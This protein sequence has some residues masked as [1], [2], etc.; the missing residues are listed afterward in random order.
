M[1]NPLPP[2]PLSLRTKVH[3]LLDA[4]NGGSTSLE[5]SMDTGLLVLVLVNALAVVLESVLHLR[6]SYRAWF[7]GIELVSVCAFTLE[8]VLRVWSAVE[9]RRYRHPVTRRLRF[10]LTPFALVDLLAILP[11]YLTLGAWTCASCASFASSGF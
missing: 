11:F 5:Q 1:P 10:A 8:Y 2:L 4:D 6:T 7:T 3:Q 9:S